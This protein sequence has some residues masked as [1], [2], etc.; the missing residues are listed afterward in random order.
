MT[1]TPD[2]LLRA[3][4][5]GIFP[6]AEDANHTDIFW[7]DPDMRGIIPLHNFHLPRSLR[8]TL[9]RRQTHKR[10]FYIRYNQ[11]FTKVL[12]GC[13][14]STLKRPN[15]WINQQIKDL[16][17]S[18][19]YSGYAHSIECYSQDNHDLIG[20]LYGIQ[21]GS[22]FFGES[23]FSIWPNAS[24]IS[25]AYLLMSLEQNKFQLLDIQFITNHLKKFGAIEI[26]RHDYKIRLTQA[27]EQ[28]NQ[29]NIHTDQDWSLAGTHFSSQTS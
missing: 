17:V 28:P 14:Q 29:F 2:L 8:K 15:T 16:Y 11:N 21:I 13:S 27:I 24:K 25:L 12:D 18:L 7:V 22:A 19:H 9:R 23:M 1:I 6:M 26:P 5:V 20:G 10:A 4:S 3:Y